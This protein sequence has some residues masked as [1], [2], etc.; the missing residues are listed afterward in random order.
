MSGDQWIP[1]DDGATVGTT[2]TEGII[3]QDLCLPGEA[4]AT[5]EK[6]GDR[7]ALTVG[8]HGWM[9]HTIFLAEKESE[10]LVAEVKEELQRIVDLIPYIED[11]SDEALDAVTDE[12]TRFVKRH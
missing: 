8:V 12:I 4:R 11:A 6:A 3:V 9:V 1:V 7:Y 2:G 5:L 10:R